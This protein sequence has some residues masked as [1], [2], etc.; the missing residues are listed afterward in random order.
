MTAVKEFKEIEMSGNRRTL[1]L[2]C[3]LTFYAAPG[4]YAKKKTDSA[5]PQVFYHFKVEGDFAG[6]EE[7][8]VNKVHLGKLPLTITREDFLKKVPFMLEPPAG[9][10][11]EKKKEMKDHWFG[12]DIIFFERES[13]I[14]RINYHPKRK[15]Y[16]ARVKLGEE[17]GDHGYSDIGGGGGDIRRDY[18][19]NIRAIFP[20]RQKIIDQNNE[21]FITLL[22]IAQVN[23]HD[24]DPQWYKTIDTYAEKGWW[25]LRDYKSHSGIPGLRDGWALWKFGVKNP[26]NVESCIK[27]FQRICEYANSKKAYYFE[28]LEGRALKQIYDKLDLNKLIAEYKKALAS[29]KRLS[30]G[31]GMAEMYGGIDYVV[32][33]RHEAKNVVPA[34]TTAVRHALYLW[35][36]KLDA[37]DYNSANPVELEIVPVL[38]RDDYIGEAVTLGG[39]VIAKYLLRQNYKTTDRK[40]KHVTVDPEMGGYINRWFR[41]LVV[42]DDPVG[43]KFRQQHK[44]EIFDLLDSMLKDQGWRHGFNGEPPH[45]LK[46]DAELG[47]ES[48]AWQYLDRHAAIL[49]LENLKQEV[50]KMRFKYL[51]MFGDLA[52]VEMYADAW[53]DIH[54]TK[55]HYSPNLC[56]GHAFAFI[57]RDKYKAFGEQ[58]IADYQKKLESLGQRNKENEDRHR[59][60]SN[61]IRGIRYDLKKHAAGNKTWNIQPPEAEKLKNTPLETL[62]AYPKTGK[63][64]K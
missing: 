56:L 27:G 61:L 51:S 20:S 62:V 23:D 47:K 54:K 45:F 13:N 59:E 18:N 17:W 3:M 55:S 58:L 12:M 25:K 4:S 49:N 52:T 46:L 30:Y 34:S 24:V 21:R 33:T 38:I 7:L 5:A 53:H 35:D 57:P 28:G 1:I 44:K 41:Y 6:G 31:G 2:V 43:R 60:Y 50:T 11:D 42:M 8:W 15:K 48:I 16:Y 22:K 40:S 14:F 9:Y 63:E 37:E 26:E 64:E 32:L 19:I 29:G 36:R 39:P 10:T